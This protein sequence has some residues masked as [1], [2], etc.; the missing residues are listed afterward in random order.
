MQ[1]FVNEVA[2]HDVAVDTALHI[3]LQRAI[4]KEGK[5]TLQDTQ[6]TTE[7]IQLTQLNAQVDSLR[8]TPTDFAARLTQLT[9]EESHGMAARRKNINTVF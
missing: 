1:S 4:I 7:P 9:F 3:T 6:Q 5:A 2:L 8:Y